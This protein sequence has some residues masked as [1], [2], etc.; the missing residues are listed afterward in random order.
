MKNILLLILSIAVLSSCNKDFLNVSPKAQLS[1]AQVSTGPE[2]L[3][4]AA[5]A[6][7]GNDHYMTPNSLWP[8]GNVR[9]G[10]AYK[11]GRD[12]ADIQEFYFMEIFKSVRSDIGQYDG[13]WFQYYVALSRINAALTNLNKLSDTDFPLKKVRQ[14]EMRFLRGHFYFQ[15]KIM[16]KNIPYIDETVNTND[17]PKISNV[18]LKNDELWEKIAADFQFGLDNLPPS[19]SQI[20][21]ANK[22][23]AAAYLAKVRLYQ[24]YEQDD[25]NNVTTVNQTKL[26]Q[27]VTL[28]DQVIGSSYHL[29]PDFADNFIPGSTENGPESIFAIQFSKDDGTMF[30]R[31]NFGDVLGTP[32]GIGCCDFHK[33]SQN[34]AN[35]FKTGSDG[36]PMF[37]DFNNSDL[38]LN[39]NTVD[40]RLDHTIAIPGHPYK[41]DPSTIYQVNWNRTPDVYGVFASLKENVQKGAYTQVGPFYANTKNKI[42]L[43]YADVLLWKAEA[44]IELGRQAEALP[45]I[46]QI[47]TRA[48]N[49]TGLLKMGGGQSVSNYHI[50]TYEDGVNC[51]WT[52]DFARNALRWERRL[53]FAMEGNRFFDLVRW[54]I[55]DTYLNSYFATEK[56]KRKY[57]KDGLFTKNRDEYCPIPLNQIRFSHDLYKQNYGYVQ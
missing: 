48:G 51:N 57:L 49:S 9:S 3:V 26:T 1:E 54:G 35:A 23:A 27:V 6:E 21:R 37:S 34:L 46:N 53:E 40:P 31:L 36:L 55:A 45:L 44:L 33:P 41:Y 14:G 42:V 10:D 29:A 22:I 2:Q 56:T 28:A 30:G 39:S 8:Y 47:R 50:S 19:Q 43:R 17:Y 32:Q 24:A 25:K 5:Y 20:G 4:Y 12:E 11:G 15:L 13:Q 7:L 52:Q 18:V 16:F 38:D